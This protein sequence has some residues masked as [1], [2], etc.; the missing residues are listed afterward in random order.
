MKKATICAL[1]LGC[2]SL[3]GVA[4]AQR[5]TDQDKQF[6]TTASQANYNE[7][8]FSKLAL[9]KSQNPTVRAFAERMVQDHTR[10]GQEMQPYAQQ[11]GITPANSLDSMH[12]QKYDQ[13]QGLSGADF[14]KQYMSDMTTDHVQAVDLFKSEEASTTLPKFKTTVR[15]GEH[16]VAEHLE[17]AKRDDAKLGVAA[18]G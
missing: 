8:T 13:L 17:M 15:K 12:Q 1:A 5:A 6:L 16:V 4:Q 14:D 2:A 3:V 7:I 11:W 10:L 9:R 18:N